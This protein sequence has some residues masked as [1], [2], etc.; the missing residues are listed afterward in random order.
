MGNNV[1][2]LVFVFIFNYDDIYNVIKAENH[3]NG[4]VIMM[5]IINLSVRR[6][7]LIGFGGFTLFMTNEGVLEGRMVFIISKVVYFDEPIID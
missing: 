7:V 3:V 6:C 2:G 5:C 1:L 4:I